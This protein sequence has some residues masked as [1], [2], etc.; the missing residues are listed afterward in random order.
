MVLNSTVDA[1]ASTQTN[2]ANNLLTSTKSFA[3]YRF[4]KLMVPVPFAYICDVV[5][6]IANRLAS[7]N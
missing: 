6:V 5:V 1:L 7:N 2:V 4:V 3:D